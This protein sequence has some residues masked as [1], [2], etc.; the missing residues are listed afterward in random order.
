MNQVLF[1]LIIA[2]VAL[3]SILTFSLIYSRWHWLL[4]L[5]LICVVPVFCFMSYESWKQAQGWPTDTDVP[6]RFLVNGAI[7]EEPDPEKGN[8]GNIFLWLIDL[9]NHE[10]A[11][12]PRAYRLDY[13]Q[14]L[15]TEV[16]TALRKIRDGQ[17]QIGE[18]KKPATDFS[19]VKKKSSR[20][21]LVKDK[22]LK[23]FNLPDPALPEK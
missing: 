7:V 5:G 15:H 22:Q 4:K 19:A 11:A 2:Y 20:L 9:D 6:E 1:S 3:I 23:F 8:E 16:Q 12:E 21:G 13:T 17:L 10:L 18:F 14:K